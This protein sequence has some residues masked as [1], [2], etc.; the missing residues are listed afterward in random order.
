MTDY[1]AYKLYCALKRHFQSKAY[2]F[3]K[4]N[5]KLK[6]SYAAFEKRNDKYFFAKLAKHK[7]PIGFLAANLYQSGDMWIGELVNESAAE[8][9]YR[10]WQKRKQSLTYYF[11]QDIEGIDN[12]VDE[13]K[14][15]GGQHPKLFQR[16]L[17]KQI[18]SETLIIIDMLNGGNL[19]K[20][21]SDKLSDPVWQ[22]EYNKLIKLSP[23]I[24]VDL[25]KYKSI[26][27]QELSKSVTH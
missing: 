8:S 4:Y 1:D 21:W 11:K 13:Y 25:D 12:I 20:Y 6:V 15:R 27:D 16:Y 19:F 26:M 22:T 23:F 24:T 14:V 10:E 18:N 9:N 7:D 5:G 17:G 3:F 2:D